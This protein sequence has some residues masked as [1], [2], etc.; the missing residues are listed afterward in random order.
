MPASQCL[1]VFVYDSF[2]SI[3]FAF[4]FPCQAQAQAQAHAGIG[5]KNS[6]IC[7][8]QQ[9][10][11]SQGPTQLRT[12]SLQFSLMSCER[13]RGCGCGAVPAPAPGIGAD[14]GQ[15]YEGGWRGEAKIREPRRLAFCVAFEHCIHPPEGWRLR[16]R[17]HCVA[18]SPPSR[19]VFWTH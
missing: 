11:P 8:L 9:A 2:S 4:A 10:H 16:Q 18:Y 17:Q 13:R 19:P 5:S 3:A 12:L 6:T 7:D 14:L 1:A 15:V